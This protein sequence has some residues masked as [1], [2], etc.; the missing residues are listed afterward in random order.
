MNLPINYIYLLDILKTNRDNTRGGIEGFLS[1]VTISAM[2]WQEIGLTKKRLIDMLNVMKND[3]VRI[4][5]QNEEG[6]YVRVIKNYKDNGNKIIIY[7]CST[8]AIKEYK[9]M[10][11]RKIRTST[12]K[13]NNKEKSA[14]LVKNKVKLY[15]PGFKTLYILHSNFPKAVS[16]MEIWHNVYGYNNMPDTESEIKERRKRV[17]DL[18]NGIQERMT[19]AGF[20]RDSISNSRQEGYKLNL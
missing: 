20:P 10:I 4:K 6:H 9:K 1:P 18:V 8:E 17:Y 13:L 11:G 5:D 15:T 7:D 19:K 14:R 3:K 16:Y 12:I 2:E